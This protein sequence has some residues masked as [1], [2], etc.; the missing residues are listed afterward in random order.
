M[1]LFYRDTVECLQTLLS[2]PLFTNA[3]DFTPYRVFTTAQRLV[4]IY[5]EWMSCDI[6]WE[7]QVGI[8]E[9][10]VELKLTRPSGQRALPEDKGGTILGVILS[11]DKTNVTNQCGGKVSHPLLMSL[12]NIH[13]EIR[14]KA[15][16]H[17]FIPVAFLPIAEF[18]HK[19]QRV[20]GVLSDRLYHEALDIVVAPLKQAA[21]IG[22]MLS[23]PLG[24]SRYCYTTLA[25]CIVD[26]PESRLIA[27]VRGMT[28]AITL[29]DY[30][31]FGDPFCHDLRTGDITLDQISSIDVDPDDV[32]AYFRACQEFRL[33]GVELPFWRDWPLSNPAYFLTP[34]VLHVFHR[35]YFDHDMRW[36]IHAVGSHEIDFRFS[37]LQPITGYRHF[38]TGIT[39]LKQ[40]TGRT[41]RDLQRYMVAVIAEAAPA[42]M[43]QAVRS[44]L[45]FRYLSQAPVIND[46]ECRK[47]SAALQ[48]FHNHKESITR[49]G[50][51]R[52]EKGNII[53]HWNIP[54]LEVMQN[55]ARNIPLVGPPI[56]WTADTTERAHIDVVKIPATATNNID[57]ES[58]ICRYLDRQEK[59]RT[60][61]L[62]LHIR[63]KEG[64]NKLQ[65][66]R[67]GMEIDLD[68]DD[69][70]R[71]DSPDLDSTGMEPGVRPIVDYFTRAAEPSRAS[72]PRIFISGPVAFH[73]G[74]KPAVSSMAIDTVADKYGLP[75]LRAALVHYIYRNQNCRPVQVGGRRPYPDD[76]LLPFQRLQVWH[77]VRIQQR[78]YHDPTTSLPAQSLIASPPGTGWPKGRYD[79]AFVNIDDSAVWPRSGLQGLSASFHACCFTHLN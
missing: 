78:T 59:C 66:E 41:F 8:L 79:T 37:I 57:F 20:K 4:R 1:R 17:G 68:D 18:L 64:E 16:L 63:D 32:Q 28:S 27:C 15:S 61:S 25:S 14:S 56:R 13:S 19:D 22:V 51:R 43:V 73:V 23:D 70:Q 24:Y 47:I 39:K 53:E 71:P 30:T 44:L 3:I 62:A 69:D 31:E 67:T 29:A 40:V 38:T 10:S 21:S 26:T 77:K 52:G 76:D 33:N 11:S 50:A 75:D 36:C 46:D 9:R 48:E 60:F 34:E 2:N 74:L 42:G 58:Q 7:M 55:V 6:A 35:F 49:A 5:T 45:E 72:P 65:G 12:A 54:K